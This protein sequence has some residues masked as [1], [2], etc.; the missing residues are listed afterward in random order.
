MPKGHVFAVGT[1]IIGQ[2]ANIFFVPEEAATLVAANTWNVP[3]VF[4]LAA[5]SGNKFSIYLEA[6]PAKQLDYLVT[7]AQ[8]VREFLSNNKYAGQSW[9][10]TPA[11]P[12]APAIP[13][14]E[15]TVQRTT[16]TTGCP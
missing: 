10:A 9:W 11:L 12:P 6:L 15:E 2:S 5:D 14:D 1:V 16:G 8:A 3:M 4:G 7:E 13:E